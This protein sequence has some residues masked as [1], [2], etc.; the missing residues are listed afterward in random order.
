MA[1]EP[2]MPTD[3]N[4]DGQLKAVR[5]KFSVAAALALPVVLIAMLPHLLD[6][7]VSSSNSQVL[8]Y[9]ELALATPV[10]LWAGFDYFRR[11]WHG[12]VNR[13]PNMYTLIGMGVLVAYSYSLAATF[14]PQYFPKEM[15]ADHGMVG[16]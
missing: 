14:A 4:D 13:S 12:V 7:S 15:K 16:V 3:E 2:L 6:V 5:R 9:L 11:G 10:V 8:R 1:L